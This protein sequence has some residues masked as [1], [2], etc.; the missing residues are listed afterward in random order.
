MK[1]YKTSLDSF[2][3]VYLFN[4]KTGEIV[5]CFANRERVTVESVDIYGEPMRLDYSYIEYLYLNNAPVRALKINLL[6]DR[7]FYILNTEKDILNYKYYDL[8]ISINLE[9]IT[10]TKEEEK[11]EKSEAGKFTT[12]AYYKVD[13]LTTEH[14]IGHHHFL[15]EEEF[16]SLNWREYER[17]S[18]CCLLDEIKEHEEIAILSKRKEKKERYI[19]FLKNKIEAGFYGL[20]FDYSTEEKTVFY[21]SKIIKIEKN[22][23]QQQLEKNKKYLYKIGIYEIENL[24]KKLNID[25]TKIDLESL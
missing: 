9:N 6:K 14:R 22:D 25:L 15:K 8:Y 12:T 19:E 1:N 13:G 24:L 10:F 4:S 3:N 11:T 2:K 21:F 23:E 17:R 20:T 18:A 5:G 7:N 16:K